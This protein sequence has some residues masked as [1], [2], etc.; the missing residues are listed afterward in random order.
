M[1]HKS[2]MKTILTI[3]M[4]CGLLAFVS[5]M[6]SPA[7]A[8]RVVAKTNLAYWATATANVGVDVAIGP[9]ST[10]GLMVGL[11]PWQFSDTKKLKHWLVQPEYRY[12]FCEAFNGHF[13]GAHLL[14]GQYNAGGVKLPFGLFPSLEKGRYQGWAVG[15]GFTYGYH[16]LLGRRWSMEFAVGLG[17]VYLDYEKYPCATCGTMQKKDSRHYFGPTKAAINLV[18]NF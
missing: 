17:Y 16:L 4:A 10:L 18:Y 6:A 12:W 3:L 8:Q 9:R 15:G 7:S 13:I 2:N 1:N 14:G 5:P 11:Q